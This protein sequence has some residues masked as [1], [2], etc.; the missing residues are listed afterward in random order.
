MKVIAGVIEGNYPTASEEEIIQLSDSD[1]DDEVICLT[2]LP[3]NAGPSR[4]ASERI[5]PKF[6]QPTRWPCRG[7]NSIDRA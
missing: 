7:W 4:Q 1:T 6:I 3:D 2:P 5:W